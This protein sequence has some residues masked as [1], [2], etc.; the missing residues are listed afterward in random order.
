M[1]PP[2]LATSIY[3]S[4]CEKFI[5]TKRLPIFTHSSFIATRK[6]CKDYLVINT[7]PDNIVGAKFLDATLILT[8]LFDVRKSTVSIATCTFHH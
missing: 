1:L 6:K 8:M 4:N 3:G 7:L 5:A 2:F